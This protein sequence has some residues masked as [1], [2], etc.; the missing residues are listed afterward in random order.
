MSKTNAILAIVILILLGFLVYFSS[1]V[2][3]LSV[4]PSSSPSPVATSGY[5]DESQ[6]K[7]WQDGNYSQTTDMTT[8]YTLKYPRDFDVNRGDS[9]NGGFIGT[10]RVKISFP[11][12][13]FATPKSN[14]GEAYV[15]IS[16]GN[17]ANSVT[18]CFSNPGNSS[19]NLTQTQTVNG[20][21][22]HTGTMQEPAAGNIYNSR[23][24]RT[25][26]QGYCYEDVLTVHT[27][28]IA[29]YDP[30]VQQFDENKAF[31]VLQKILATLQFFQK[32]G[33]L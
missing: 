11:Q 8:G 31:S 6:W 30:G 4:K 26:Y 20:V 23:I 5:S 21:E 14:F 16:S 18:K 32:K 2:A 29:N 9:A 3:V 27:G 22:F 12:D 15:T 33:P 19:Q 7:I 28:N 10:P 25:L 24:Y 13:A 1:R 17:D